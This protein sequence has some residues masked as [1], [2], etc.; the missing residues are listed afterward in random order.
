MED[1]S[2]LGPDRTP[3]NIEVIARPYPVSSSAEPTLL[4]FDINVKN[5]VIVLSGD[6]IGDSPTI[7][8]LPLSIT[9]PVL[10]SGQPMEWDK[11]KIK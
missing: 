5:A 8:I 9:R 6:I 11:A 7:I 1:F 2:L 3:R 10:E 4:S